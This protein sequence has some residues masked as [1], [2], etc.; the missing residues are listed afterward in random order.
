MESTDDATTPTR[1]LGILLQKDATTWVSPDGTTTLRKETNDGKTRWVL[2]L[3]DGASV[4]LG[5]EFKDGDFGLR[6]LTL[7]ESN[8][9]QPRVGDLLPKDFDTRTSDVIDENYDLDGNVIVTQAESP[10][11][12]DHLIGTLGADRIQ[13]KGGQDVLEG[14]R[15][16]ER[17]FASRRWRHGDKAPNA[18]RWRAAA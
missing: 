9:A 1:G 14:D 4:D 11:R 2:A 8:P 12:N 6:R 13:G 5:S 10:G 7:A 3:P 16:A 17:S 18:S 15:A